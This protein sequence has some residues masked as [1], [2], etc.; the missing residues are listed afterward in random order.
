MMCGFTGAKDKVDYAVDTKLLD[1]LK[2]SCPQVLAQL[3]RKV[4]RSVTFL[5][6]IL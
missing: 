4:A 3:E 6:L 2:P 5:F 1:V